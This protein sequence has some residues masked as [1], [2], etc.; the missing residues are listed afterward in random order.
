MQIGKYMTLLQAKNVPVKK[1]LHRADTEV[2]IVWEYF[3]K[4]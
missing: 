3:P 2:F 4:V 1:H